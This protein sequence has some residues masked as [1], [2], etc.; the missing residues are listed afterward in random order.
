MWIALDQARVT[1]MHL[2][3]GCFT[4]RRVKTSNSKVGEVVGSV[5]YFVHAKLDKQFT[6]IDQHNFV[7]WKL[8]SLTC[9]CLLFPM[10]FLPPKFLCPNQALPLF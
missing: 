8:M 6:N 1:Q 10:R 7:L 4:T 9:N 5:K 3:Q 2:G